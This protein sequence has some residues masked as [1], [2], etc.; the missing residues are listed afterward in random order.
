MLVT[1]SQNAEIK[2]QRHCKADH[3]ARK[4]L[5]NVCPEK[6]FKSPRTG[7]F[8]FSQL[9]WHNCGVGAPRRNGSVYTLRD[10]SRLSI[11]PASLAALTYLCRALA[12]DNMHNVVM[13]GSL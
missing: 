4:G 2:Q 8:C 13:K 11:R 5:R 12:A 6:Y 10:L 1:L 9:L 3:D 7:H